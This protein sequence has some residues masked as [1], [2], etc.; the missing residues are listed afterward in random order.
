MAGGKD[1]FIREGYAEIVWYFA[2]KLQQ[3]NMT[4]F[5][6]GSEKSIAIDCASPLV[7]IC[8]FPT[9]SSISPQRGIMPAYIKLVLQASC[10]QP[11][12]H[13]VLSTLGIY[14]KDFII[15]FGIYKYQCQKN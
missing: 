7:L 2:S 9:P 12:H 6:V 13:I 4:F 14:I 1:I 11:C 15:C 10:A 5:F 3:K 8:V